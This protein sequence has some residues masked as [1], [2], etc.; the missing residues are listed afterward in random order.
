[1]DI[2]DNLL[3]KLRTD[4]EEFKKLHDQH[5]ELKSKVDELSKL[6][7]MSPEQEIEKK[8]HQKEKLILKDRL[9][10]IVSQ[11]QGELH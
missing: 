3:Q 9:G 7:F 8:N 11:Y 5:L 4:N 10:K 2:D 1:M 6:K